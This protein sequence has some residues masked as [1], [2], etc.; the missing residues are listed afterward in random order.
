MP[1]C[2]PL[3][4]IATHGSQAAAGT[5]L[6]ISSAGAECSLPATSPACRSWWSAS[7]HC[8]CP[9]WCAWATTTHGKLADLARVTFRWQPVA[10]SCLQVSRKQHGMQQ[11]KLN[12]PPRAAVAPLAAAAWPDLYLTLR[13]SPP[14]PAPPPSRL[15]SRCCPRQVQPDAQRAA[16]LRACDAA[17]QQPGYARS[18]HRRCGLRAGVA[19]IVHAWK[20]PRSREM[21]S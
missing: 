3:Q 10:S 15:S 13:P 19:G 17:E 11:E 8:R 21:C 14:L 9:R 16:P 1:C 2:W 12:L 4:H 20:M 5:K 6:R 18:V 7:L